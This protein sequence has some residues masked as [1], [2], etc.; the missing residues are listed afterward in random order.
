MTDLRFCN[1]DAHSVARRTSRL[2]FSLRRARVISMIVVAPWIAT[3]VFSARDAWAEP[4]PPSAEHL[5]AEG[6]RLA[7][8]GDCTAARDKFADSYATDPAPGTLIN[9]ALC[10]ERLG[11]SGT[12]LELLRVADKALPAAHP[13]RAGLAK[14][15]ESLARRAP[16]LRLRLLPSA[17]AGTTIV[18]DEVAVD[19]ASYTRGA[20]QD[21]GL[22]I[23]EVRAPGR[24]SRR[25]EAV[26]V[27]GR[28]L[29]MP[30]EPGA[31]DPA[32]N[33][34]AT[35]PTSAPGR[36]A[37]G[38]PAT[39]SSTTLAASDVEAVNRGGSSSASTWG[40]GLAGGGVAAIGIGAVTGLLANAEWSEVK[41]HCDVDRKTCSSEGVSASRTGD[42]LAT[43]S[44]IA[45]VA[46]GVGLA[47]GS[48]LL[49]TK[50]DAPTSARVSAGVLPG[51]INVNLGGSF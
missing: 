24:S 18:I 11:R 1:D 7:H 38:G 48:Y 26:L 19:V 47:I 8:S 4:V 27:E 35:A 45:F 20:L 22:H 30:V 10:E 50:K 33:G 34:A 12:A 2:A 43:T 29:E 25:Y 15:L 40:W 6:L 17:P 36:G 13:K 9:W 5:F 49:L 3:P 42:A 28:T 39:S 46:G 31:A 41:D 14:H 23:V 32:A 16:I 51:A 44:T 21:P 37:L